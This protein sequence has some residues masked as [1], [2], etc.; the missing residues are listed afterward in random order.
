MRG[1]ALLLAI[2]CTGCAPEV[3]LAPDLRYANARTAHQTAS[4]QVALVT[5]DVDQAYDVLG[6][7]EVV[8]RQ[9]GT[10]GDKPTREIAEAALRTQAGRLGAHAVILVAFGQMGSSWWSYNELRGHGRAVRFR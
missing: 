4:A 1:L 9:R 6:D 10:F 3:S 2:A 5:T 7:L 8:V